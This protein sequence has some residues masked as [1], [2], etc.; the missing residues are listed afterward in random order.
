MVLALVAV[1]VPA[2]VVEAAE[3]VEP[4]AAEL[5]LEVVEPP[6]A[7]LVEEPEDPMQDVEPD[8]TVKGAELSVAPVLSRMLR[9]REVPEVMLTVH[10]REVPDCWPK[11]T[12]AAAEGCPPGRMETK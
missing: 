11:S 7:L 4:P 3:V 12:R 10:V 9:P 2:A 6:A 8:W 1:E 5:E